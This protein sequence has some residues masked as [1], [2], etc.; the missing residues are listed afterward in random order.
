MR[1]P[2]AFVVAA[3]SAAFVCGAQGQQSIPRTDKVPSG[4]NL[5]YDA[6]HRQFTA[7]GLQLRPS[8]VKRGTGV[9]PT[10]GLVDVTLNINLISKYNKETSFPCS[11]IVIAGNIDLNTYTVEGGLETAYGIA[12]RVGGT[13]T[14]VCKLSIPY[15]LDLTAGSAASSGLIVAYAVAAVNGEGNT[16]RSALQLSGIENLPANDST[17]KFSFDAAL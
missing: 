7:S 4:L 12:Y 9:T 3:L 6:P 5:S 11:A 14:A 15:S 17:L 8:A 1:I 2:H 13:S 10:T 16:Q